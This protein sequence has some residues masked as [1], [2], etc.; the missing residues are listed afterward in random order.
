MLMDLDIQVWQEAKRLKPEEELEEVQIGLEIFQIARIKE[1]L[2][3][4]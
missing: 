1:P 4:S 2:D 3:F